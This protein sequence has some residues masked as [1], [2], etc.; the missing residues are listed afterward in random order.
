LFFSVTATGDDDDVL[1]RLD[2]ACCTVP[3]LRYP[4]GSSSSLGGYERGAI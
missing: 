1:G 2:D 4:D 3:A